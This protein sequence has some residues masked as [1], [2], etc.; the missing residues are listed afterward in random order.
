VLLVVNGAF[1]D[2]EDEEDEN[3]LEAS[4]GDRR[5]SKNDYHHARNGDHLMVPFECD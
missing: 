1:Q 3:R 5:S 4:W 2:L